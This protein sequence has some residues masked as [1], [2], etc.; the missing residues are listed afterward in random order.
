MQAKINHYESFKQPKH[1]KKL[2]LFLITLVMG[3]TTWADVGDEF[4]A[5]GL[6]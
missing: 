2:L 3:T 1:M 5:D 6:K 4:T